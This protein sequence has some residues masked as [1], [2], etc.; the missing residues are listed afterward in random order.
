MPVFFDVIVNCTTDG[1]TSGENEV[2]YFGAT[3]GYVY[4]LESGPNFDGNTIAAS[5][6][7]N[8]NPQ[9]ESRYNKRYR[10]GSLEIQGSSYIELSVGYDLAYSDATRVDME[11]GT[12]VS[13]SFAASF[14]D[15]FVWDSFVWDG[16]SLA[17]VEVEIRGT[18]ENIALRITSDGNY[19]SPF[20]V[21]SLI[22]HYN[23]RK[24]LR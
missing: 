10:K 23:M 14:W 20:T 19:F 3:N 1:E 6:F 24:A 11:L 12:T 4:R 17:P 18:A 2:A 22:L 9:G 13:P 21:N 5:L 8:Y 16:R 15:T 7:F